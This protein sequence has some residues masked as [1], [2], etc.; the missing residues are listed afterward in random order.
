MHDRHSVWDFTR[1]VPDLVVLSLGI[2]TGDPDYGAAVGSLLLQLF[3]AYVPHTP[4]VA[5]QH[6][7]GSSLTLGWPD[8]RPADRA[9]R[10]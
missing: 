2:G 4:E 9:A 10:D 3:A 7:Q 5:S 8:V 1:F 6:G